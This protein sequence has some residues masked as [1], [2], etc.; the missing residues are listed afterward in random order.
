MHCVIVFM[1]AGERLVGGAGQ[2]QQQKR[3]PNQRVGGEKP[4][5]A[6][7]VRAGG[8]RGARPRRRRL[9]RRAAAFRLQALGSGQGQQGEI[10]VDEQMVRQAVLQAIAKCIRD[11]CRMRSI[12]IQETEEPEIDLPLGLGAQAS[13]AIEVWE[14]VKILYSTI[15]V[16]IPSSIYH[17]WFH[18]E[19]LASACMLLPDRKG[20]FHYTS[21]SFF[22]H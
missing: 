12:Q 22:S 13:L 10:S 5:R 8:L 11:T 16:S 17:A 7:G 19:T 15:Y 4:A 3:I 6:A 1:H 14:V 18:N 21:V 9:L 20:L 2:Q